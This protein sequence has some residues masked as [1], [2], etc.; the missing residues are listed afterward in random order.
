MV[1]RASRPVAADP[2]EVIELFEIIASL[3][4]DAG[5]FDGVIVRSVGTKYATARDFLSGA[6]AA[7]TGGRWNPPGLPAIYAS[8]DVITA[9]REAY[10][11]FVN[12]GFP[13][14][15]ISPRVTAGA[16]ATLSKM[17][18]LT[19]ETVLSQ[20][21]FSTADLVEEEWQAIQDGGEESWTQAIGRGCQQAGFEGLLAVSA[22]NEDGKN[23]VIF[24]ENWLKRARSESW[25][26]TS[27]SE[28]LSIVTEAAKV[29]GIVLD[30][31][32]AWRYSAF[33]RI[34]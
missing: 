10:Q 34:Y 6:G 9:T 17:L 12:F 21:G 4:A 23:I 1:K 13:M 28:Y 25:E 19:D 5:G 30:R 7:R 18:D 3:Y 31:V 26:R 8:L 11:N 16:R 33:R 27:C 22:Q 20:I 32:L 24:P 15:A 29:Q 2:P 14:T